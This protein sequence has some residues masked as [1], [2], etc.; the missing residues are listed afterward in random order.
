MAHGCSSTAFGR[1]A[2]EGA[3]RAGPDAPNVGP[4]QHQLVERNVARGR[5]GDFLNGSSHRDLLCDRRPKASL[6]LGVTFFGLI[7]TPSFYVINRLMAE[8]ITERVR[9]LRALFGGHA[10]AVASETVPS[11]P[12][13][14]AGD[15]A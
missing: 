12:A 5:Q 2:H 8:W 13:G 4:V 7:F 9:R 3:C 15:A 10:P 1:G 11:A 6:G 14:P